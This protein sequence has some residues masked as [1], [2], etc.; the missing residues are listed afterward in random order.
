M[1]SLDAAADAVSFA[2]VARL[3]AWLEVHHAESAGVWIRVA[4]KG[5]GVPSVTAAEIIDVALCF[6]W[7]DGQ[8]RGLDETYYLQRITPR[9]RRSTW[10]QV[11]V[12][13]V[14]ALEAAGR[15]RAAGA[16]EVAAAKAD[17]RWDA[18]YG[19]QREAVVPADLEAALAGRAEARAFFESLGKTDRYLAM[20]P[21]LKATAARRGGQLG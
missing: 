18:A 11:N 8:R 4:K 10:S 21:L 15:M 16:A 14:A 3:E 9:R 17:G 19:S 12:R 2:D 6:G 20:L 5:S 7:I 13:K 1:N